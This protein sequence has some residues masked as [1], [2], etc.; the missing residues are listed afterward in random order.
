MIK[1]KI[2]SFR[3]LTLDVDCLVGSQLR[4]SETFVSPHGSLYVTTWALR[5]IT[6]RTQEEMFQKAK[7]ETADQ[8]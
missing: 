3:G 7:V 6:C 2:V 4:L 5:N 1:S 8:S